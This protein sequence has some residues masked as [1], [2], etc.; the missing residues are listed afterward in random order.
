[1]PRA[2]PG[3][4]TPEAKNLRSAGVTTRALFA[5]GD[6][7]AGKTRLA[8]DL[9]RDLKT[10]VHA[11]MLHEVSPHHGSWRIDANRNPHHHLVCT[12]CRSITDLPV[13]SLAPVKLR[14]AIPSGFRVEK[15]NIELQG[16]CRA[17]ANQMV[18][19]IA[20]GVD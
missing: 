2:R 7:R 5:G 17:C 19:G 14:G 13:A 18:M 6:L 11:G 15:F 10:F 3:G 12:R 4:D 9:T 8:V 1:M 20:V 16:I